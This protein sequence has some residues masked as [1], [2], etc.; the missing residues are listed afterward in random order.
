MS[1]RLHYLQ[2]VPF[3]GPGRILQWAESAGAAITATRLYRHEPLPATNTFD[4][5]VIMGG[6]MSTHDTDRHP[7]LVPEKALIRHAVDAGKAV[8]GI[9]LGAQLVAEALGARVYPNGQREIGWFEIQRSASAEGH[10]LG[11]CLPSRLTVFHWHGE[12]FDLPS[13]ALALARSEACRHQGFVFGRRVV[14]LQFHLETTPETLQALIANGG[15]DLRPGP[16]VQTP[17]VMRRGVEFC[18][19]NHDAL[20][21]F[22]NQLAAASPRIT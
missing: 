9:C 21:A 19:S 11:A 22:L 7:W 17:E 20:A 6:P 15:D 18:A 2:H 4:L 12:T 14:G 3:E 13:G 1:L 5:L 8:L 16:Y 10:P